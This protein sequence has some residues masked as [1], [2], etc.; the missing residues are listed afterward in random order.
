MTALLQAVFPLQAGEKDELLMD[1]GR[2][3]KG[4]YATSIHELSDQIA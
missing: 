1:L 4:S 2:L 3:D